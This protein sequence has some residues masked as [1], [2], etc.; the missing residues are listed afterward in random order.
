MKGSTSAGVS[1]LLPVVS[2]EDLAWQMLCCVM[3][4]QDGAAL[5]SSTWL[6]LGSVQYCSKFVRGLLIPPR[7]TAGFRL[8][9]WPVVKSQRDVSSQGQKSLLKMRMDADGNPRHKPGA[10]FQKNQILH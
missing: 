1:E 8:P 5:V 3:K 4:E 2:A 7:S 6:G 9:V 10:M